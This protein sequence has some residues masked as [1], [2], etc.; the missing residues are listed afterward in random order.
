MI[1]KNIFLVRK[2]VRKKMTKSVLLLC[3][4]TVALL[5]LA[6]KTY[7]HAPELHK[8]ES[9]DKP[10]CEAMQKMDHSDMDKD[11]EDPIMQAMM[12]QCKDWLHDEHEQDVKEHPSD[13]HDKHNQG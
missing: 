7:A 6:L 11:M 8:K 1:V 13:G 10:Q 9:A 5:T 2:N 4:I 3:G 12:E